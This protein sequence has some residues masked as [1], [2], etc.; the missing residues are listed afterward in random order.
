M[1]TPSLTSDFRSALCTAAISSVLFTAA[2]VEIVTENKANPMQLL[3]GTVFA[4]LAR[5]AYKSGMSQIKALESAQA[6]ATPPAP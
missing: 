1:A 6:P 5:S 4:A 3:M 2:A